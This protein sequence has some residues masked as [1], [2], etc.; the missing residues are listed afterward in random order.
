MCTFVDG[1]HTLV[2]LVDQAACQVLDV[3]TP[4][5]ALLP[6]P[7]N[8]QGSCSQPVH[9]VARAACLVLPAG[10]HSTAHASGGQCSLDDAVQVLHCAREALKA[11]F[12]GARQ[13]CIV[14]V[15]AL[16]HRGTR[17]AATRSF[18]NSEKH[19][20]VIGSGQWGLACVV[21]HPVHTGKCL[22]TCSALISES[23]CDCI[24]RSASV[25]RL[26]SACMM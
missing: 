20:R 24:W 17:T 15:H 7:A 18:T 4:L 13:L 14:A 10:Q 26:T 11:A 9:A 19:M 21:P 16:L 12:E 6:A 3:S 25:R 23:K 5:L 2:D 22:I 8:S 1:C